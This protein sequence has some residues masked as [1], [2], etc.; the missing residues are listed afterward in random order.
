[1]CHANSKYFSQVTFFC[2]TVVSDSLRPHGL[3]YSFPC[4]SQSPRACSISCPSS[5][6]CHPTILS[7][8]VSFSCL[9]RFPESGAFLM[10]QFFTSGGQSIGALASASALPMNIQNWF[11][12]GLMGLISLPSK[13]LWR[14]FSTTTV[15]KHPV[16]WHSA[17]IMPYNDPISGHRCSK[18]NFFQS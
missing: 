18:K 13:G 15:Q 1:M 12:L 17:F 14:V 10:N 16:L 6:W 5:Q 8:V 11:P 4:P 3:Q 9:Q 7:S 2:C